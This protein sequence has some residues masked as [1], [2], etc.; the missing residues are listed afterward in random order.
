MRVILRISRA[1]A[2]CML[3]LLLTAC[4][5]PR[6]GRDQEQTYAG[7]Y[8]PYLLDID[9]DLEL[10]GEMNSAWANPGELVDDAV[11]HP[12]LCVGDCL[13]EY[14]EDGHGFLPW[15]EP[16]DLT[17]SAEPA[18]PQRTAPGREPAQRMAR[19]RSGRGMVSASMPAGRIQRP[20]HEIAAMC[21]GSQTICISSPFGVQR[22]GHLHKGVDI[23]APFGSLIKAFRSGVVTEAR[24]H[25]S[26]GKVV[27]VRQDDGL[28]ARYAHMSQILVK[29]GDRVWQG[30]PIG[31]V[32]S[33]GRSTGPHLHFE[34]IR[35]SQHMNPMAQLQAPGHVVS[36][37]TERDTVQARA[38][39]ASGGAPSGWFGY[40]RRSR[41]IDR[42]APVRSGR[43]AMR[44]G[45][46]SRPDPAAAKSAKAGPKVKGQDVSSGKKAAAK[47]PAKN[48]AAASGEAKKAGKNASASREQK[49]SGKNTQKA[50]DAGKK[51]A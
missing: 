33:T 47:A 45:K 49:P 50:H 21:N 37:A 46:P 4:L 40:A 39:T 24:W 13:T 8:V 19:Q 38:V 15:E 2:C 5:G 35:G 27:D 34:L 3:A 32:G 7:G 25:H 1:A 29:A 44:S 9:E 42:H 36:Y 14:D 12:D 17:L 20:A 18:R 31:R 48:Q 30:Q 51:A 11:S 22:P 16:D 23:S 6:S 43:F 10:D 41:V 26:Y 28:I